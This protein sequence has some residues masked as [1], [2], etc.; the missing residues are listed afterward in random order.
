MMNVTTVYA[1]DV[2]DSVHVTAVLRVYPD[3][4]REPS[5]IGYEC[6][7]TFPGTGESDPRQYLEDVLVGLLE[8]L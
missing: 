3:D 1:Y 4:S 2:L 6:T 7:T 8:A 5:Y